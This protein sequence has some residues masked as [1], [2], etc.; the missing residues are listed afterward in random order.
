MQSQISGAP[1]WMKSEHYDIA[2]T[3]ERDLQV[4]EIRAR[5]QRLLE[6]RFQLKSHWEAKEGPAYHLVVNH[7]D[8]LKTQW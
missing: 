5:L 1:D 3:A 7:A 4:G 8:K 6:D 2:A